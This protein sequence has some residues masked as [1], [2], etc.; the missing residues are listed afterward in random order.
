MGAVRHEIRTSR[1][2]GRGNNMRRVDRW[3]WLGAWLTAIGLLAGCS[4]HHFMTQADHKLYPR[5]AL[6]GETGP[7]CTSPYDVPRS[8]ID[9]QVRTI[10]SPEAKAREITL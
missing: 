6:C 1:A 10:L 4:Q 9:G 3:R 8:P 7:D 5:Q 2:G